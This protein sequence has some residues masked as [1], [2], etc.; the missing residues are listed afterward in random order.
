MFIRTDQEI[1]N[2][3]RAELQW[4]SKLNDSVI[5]SEVRNGNVTL[6]G[7]VNTY[8]KKIAAEKIVKKVPG[9]R[10]V[11]NI[12]EVT[13]PEGTR[14]SDAE[15]KKSVLNALKWNSSIDENKITVKVKDGWV[16]LQG[17][18]P[19]DYQRAKARLLAEDITGVSGVANLI[20]VLS[21]VPTLSG[22]QEKIEDAFK[23]NLYLDANKIAVE[24]DGN[25]VILSGQVRTL[26]EKSVAENAV[27]SAP[28]IMQVDNQ[29]EVNYSEEY[30]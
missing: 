30:A 10:S 19:W 22:I 24:V 3:V 16:T 7:K 12:L 9:V 28:G 5:N 14:K 6:L 11:N 26:A 4:N 27:W 29:L 2:D 20:T 18:V 25:K 8:P 23:R 15:I 21:V 17:N 13:I 1:R